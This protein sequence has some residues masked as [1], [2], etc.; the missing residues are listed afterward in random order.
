MPRRFSASSAA[1]LMACPGSANLELAIK[2]YV[3]PVKDPDA[4]AKGVGTVLH[5]FMDKHFTHTTPEILRIYAEV[6]R[7]FAGTYVIKRRE[8]CDDINARVLWLAIPG[9][10]ME[11]YADIMDW[12]PELRPYPPKTLRFLADTAS[13]V[14]DWKERMPV[15]AVV[16]GEE[17]VK[18]VWLPSV[19]STTPDIAIVGPTVLE[20]GDYKTG[21]IKVD[22]TDNDQLLFYAAC[23]MWAAPQATEFTVHVMQPDNIDSWTAPI[24]YLQAW[25]KKAIEADRKILAKDLTLNPSDHCTF[26]PANP[27]GRGDKSEAKCPAQQQILYPPVFDEDE[28]FADS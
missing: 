21:A 26:C 19:P 5:A 8:I 14:A 27:W 6:L 25:M 10:L 15:N 20:I 28:L 7:D 3:E 17:S 2:G 18:A 24:S 4:G 12:L 11:A 22:P 9:M 13:Y 16:Y 1:Q 23:W